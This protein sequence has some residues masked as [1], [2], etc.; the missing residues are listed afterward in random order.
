MADRITVCGFSAG[1]HLAASLG[2]LYD[3]P[4]FLERFGRADYIRPDALILAYSCAKVPFE[5][6][7]FPK[8]GHGMSVCT[9]EVGT[10]SEYNARWVKWSIKWLKQMFVKESK[11]E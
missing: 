4:E 10:P 1:G 7:V 8:G 11:A 9:E 5:Y 3:A 2:T 6:H